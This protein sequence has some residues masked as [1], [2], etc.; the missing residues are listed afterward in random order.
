MNDNFVHNPLKHS[1]QLHDKP[2]APSLGPVTAM[3]PQ[4]NKK[5]FM[6]ALILYG[7]TVGI[8]ITLGI[9]H[10]LP[11]QKINKKNKT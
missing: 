1:I 4:K 10:L 6:I 8:L 9:I 5:G 7:A 11:S 2:V 3:T